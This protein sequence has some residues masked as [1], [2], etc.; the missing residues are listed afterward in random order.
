MRIIADAMGGD[1]A[2][3]EQVKGA[4]AA[5]EKLGIEIILC[6]DREKIEPLI[7]G[8]KT[9]GIEIVHCSEVIENDDD[10]IRAVRR[11]TDSS[12]VVGMNLL[13]EGKGDAIVSAGNTGALIAAS[14]FI[15]KKTDGVIRP[16]LTPLLPSDKGPFALLDAGANSTCTPENLYQF[17]VMGSYYMSCVSGIKNPRVALVNIGAEEKKG[18]Q[19]TKE[20]YE[21]LKNSQLN[22]VGNIEARNVPYG[23]ADVVVTDGFTGNVML[24]LYEGLG[25]YIGG[26]VKEIFMKNIISKIAA[27]M[28]GG[29]IKSFRKKMDYKEYGGAPLL[30]VGGTVIKA[31]GSSDARAMLSAFAQAKKAC[32]SGLCEAIRENLGK[33]EMLVK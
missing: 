31:H 8:R 1:Y 32:E 10:P 33:E 25:K 11:K 15:L 2:P 24:K 18:T 22:F 4:L 7:K 13:R 23:E 6:G 14:S 17:A 26:E 16:A 21:L 3:V 27:L 28:V 5:V 9:D 19:L 20:A 12:L 29:G 30:G